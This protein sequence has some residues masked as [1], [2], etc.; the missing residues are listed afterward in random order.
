MEPYAP[1][2]SNAQA[3]VAAGQ[4]NAAQTVGLANANG[5]NLEFGAYVYQF[6]DS[7]YHTPSVSSAFRDANGNAIVSQGAWQSLQS[8][9]PVNATNITRD[10]SHPSAAANFSQMPSSSSDKKTGDYAGTFS[11][12]PNLYDSIGL[13]NGSVL[14]YKQTMDFQNG[15]FIKVDQPPVTL[16]PEQPLLPYNFLDRVE[17]PGAFQPQIVAPSSGSAAGGFLLYPNKPNNNFVQSVYA[18]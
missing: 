12:S 1:Y 8:M 3:H 15:S 17:Y 9:I 10:H 5:M 11:Y 6:G 18:K 4:Y 13:S 2:S 14:G 16:A 7:W